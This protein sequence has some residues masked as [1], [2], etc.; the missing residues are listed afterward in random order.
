MRMPAG[1]TI[2]P[3]DFSAFFD[4]DT[5]AFTSEIVLGGFDLCAGW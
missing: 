4:Y 3:C 1:P 2:V 5:K